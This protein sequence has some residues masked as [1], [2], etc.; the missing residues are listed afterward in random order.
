MPSD[1][2]WHAKG[3]DILREIEAARQVVVTH[4]ASPAY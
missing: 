3:E 2:V 1:A 4:Q